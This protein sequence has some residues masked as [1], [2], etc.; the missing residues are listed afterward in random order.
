MW[1]PS[2]GPFH[3]AAS[4]IQTCLSRHPLA[5]VVAAM[6]WHGFALAVYGSAL[7]AWRLSKNLRRITGHSWTGD[8]P[9]PTV[10]AGNA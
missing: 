10:H 5:H 4:L 3:R 8:P 7:V 9:N 2:R 6:T 1:G